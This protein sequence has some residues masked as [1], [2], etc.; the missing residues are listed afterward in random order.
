MRAVDVIRKKGDGHPLLP[1]EIE[2]FVTG[3]TKKTWPDYQVSALLMAILLRGMDPVET[4]TLTG[5]MVRS[6]VRLDLSDLPGVKVDKHSTGGVGD[7]TSLILAPLAAACGVTV[8]MMSGRGLGHTGGTLDKL[9]AIPGFRVGLSLPEFR[10]A[11]RKVGCALIGQT[12]E[13]APA[14]KI[15]YALRDVTATVES[16]PLITGSILSKKIA[17]GIEALVLDVKCG[18]GAFM[19]T[20]ADARRLAESLVA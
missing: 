2:A 11:L 9:E 12:A 15:L 14:D 7:K 17:E 18:R 19:K 4:A 8:P 5:A 6:G 13:I 20:R 3:A 16:I 10:A 1:H